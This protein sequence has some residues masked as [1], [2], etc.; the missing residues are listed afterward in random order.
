VHSGITKR[1]DAVNRKSGWTDGLHRRIMKI[2]EK[3]G[4]ILIKCRND[5]DSSIEL[6][7]RM[8]LKLEDLIDEK[9]D[10]YEEATDEDVKK[11][12]GPL[13]ILKSYYD[14]IYLS[15]HD[16]KYDIESDAELFAL[17]AWKWANSALDFMGSVSLDD[18][19]NCNS[20]NVSKFASACEAAIEAS[21]AV[22]LALVAF[23]KNKNRSLA[24]IFADDEDTDFISWE[25][26]KEKSEG[27]D[28]NIALVKKGLA[29]KK[30]KVKSAKNITAKY[31]KTLPLKKLALSYLLDLI[32]QAEVEP[33]NVA[34]NLSD[35]I[36]PERI[37]EKYRKLIVPQHPEINL[38]KLLEQSKT[39]PLHIS[40]HQLANH[41]RPILEAKADKDDGFLSSVESTTT[42][43]KWLLK[44]NG[45]LFSWLSFADEDGIAYED[46]EKFIKYVS[47][48][49]K[50]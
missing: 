3:A 25:I 49:F 33:D 9:Y 23:S 22:T 45:N 31:Q 16:E 40:I 14:E 13:Q 27:K 36:H 10:L 17:F 8:G 32:G 7:D 12:T 6:F 30:S 21:E 28:S 1:N 26:G 15:F 50:L 43:Y 19:Q 4:R 34:I 42:V 20:E 35:A 46:R 39:K 11:H 18:F 38:S 2:T 44:Y 41:I 29:G 47:D 5:K 37:V 48:E 24:G